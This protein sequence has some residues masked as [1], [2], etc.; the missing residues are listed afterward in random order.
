MS[1][2]G[3]H[4]E[5]LIEKEANGTLD[6]SER[7]QLDT[8][9]AQCAACRFE[10]SVR[11]DF[12]S[13][14]AGEDPPVRISGFELE[15][16]K[17][18]EHVLVV[19]PRRFRYAWVVAAAVLLLVATAFASEPGRRVWMPMLGIT[20]VGQAPSVTM[21][22]TEI[23]AP[24]PSVA[25]WAPITHEQP[26]PVVITTE[27]PKPEPAPVAV[28]TSQALFD[29]ESD[30][31]RRGDYDRA[32]ALHT[33][34]VTKYPQSKEAQV[35]RVTVARMLLDRGE[36]SNAL[37]G[38]DAYIA[39][40]GGENMEDALVGRATCLDKLG[41][42]EEARTAWQ[43]LLDRHPDGPWASHAKVRIEALGN[44]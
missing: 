7:K 41:K 3:L 18:Q 17:K 12:A 34:L 42:S 16:P 22:T 26:D 36:P 15:Q 39:H 35:S 1:V 30:A 38:F 14:L 23:V 8:H 19:R 2:T 9:V 24:P 21:P 27:D 32:I 20:I 4:P 5:H 6:A 25:H 11:D 44:P 43:T 40:G 13:E 10:R 29:D 28:Q 31:R 33:Q 37:V